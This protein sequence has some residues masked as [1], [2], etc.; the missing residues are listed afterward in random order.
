MSRQFA[1]WD[2]LVVV[3][4]CSSSSM[5]TSRFRPLALPPPPLIIIIIAAG[6]I[7]IYPTCDRVSA[8]SI[9]DF[10]AGLVGY[11]TPIC[12]LLPHLYKALSSM[13]AHATDR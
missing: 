13:L 9:I 10:L 12:E 8:I 6:L 1:C 11:I 2:E 4:I 3:V 7:Y 5:A